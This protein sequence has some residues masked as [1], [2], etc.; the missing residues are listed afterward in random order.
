MRLKRSLGGSREFD[1]EWSES[2][3]G[4][5]A[6]KR[7]GEVSPPPEKGSRNG[8]SRGGFQPEVATKA[9]LRNARLP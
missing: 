1:P 2:L 8:S 7:R 9:R 3:P 4:C 5:A 6:P